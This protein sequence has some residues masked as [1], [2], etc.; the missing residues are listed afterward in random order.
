MAQSKTAEKKLFDA[1]MRLAAQQGWRRTSLA[2]IAAEAGTTLA[3]LQASYSGKDDILAAFTRHID[4]QVLA[5]TVPAEPD[6]EAEENAKDRLFDVLMRRFDA[7]KP[8]KDGL[9]RI[10]NEGGG[11]S[12]GA[13]LCAGA[14]LMK[15]MA[16][17]LEA[18][19]IS[20]AGFAGRLRVKGLAAVYLSVMPTWFRDDTVDQ[21]RTM[22][23]LD[24]A[25]SQ[26]ERF[27]TMRNPFGG[28]RRPRDEEAAEGGH[29]P[30]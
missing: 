3:D 2:D 4:Q 11:D 19:G 7:L 5:G 12:I 10:A 28:P 18:A 9:K 23:R 6:P 27:A 24:K 21:S 26:A 15:S 8:Y 16:W 20:A 25:L 29:A 30:A 1:T 14:R 13:S 22:A 17:M